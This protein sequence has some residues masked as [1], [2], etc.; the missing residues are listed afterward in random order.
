MND[1]ENSSSK[2]L[3]AHIFDIVDGKIL[4]RRTT[5]LALAASIS[6]NCSRYEKF[7][8]RKTQ[9]DPIR[10]SNSDCSTKLL[11]L[12]SGELGREVALEAMRYG[13]EVIAADRYANAPAMQFAHWS[14]ATDSRR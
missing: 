13:V 8:T 12:G 3:Y 5:S 1:V 7:C 14:H 6:E 11:P 10:N 2:E 4:P 9:N